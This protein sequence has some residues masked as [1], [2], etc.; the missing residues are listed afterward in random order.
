MQG[1]PKRQYRAKLTLRGINVEQVDCYVSEVLS[2]K[3]VV[4]KRM[5]RDYYYYID[6]SFMQGVYTYIPETNHVPREHCVAAFLMLLFMVHISLVPV[7]TAS[8]R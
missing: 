4:W 7:L 3:L 2:Q 1:K 6:I 8:L 5:S